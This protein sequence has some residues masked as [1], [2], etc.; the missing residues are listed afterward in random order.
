MRELAV[1]RRE[2]HVLGTA[3]LAC[4]GWCRDRCD[5]CRRRR[6]SCAATGQERDDERSMHHRERLLHRGLVKSLPKPEG[7]LSWYLRCATDAE[8]CRPQQP[9][10]HRTYAALAG[11]PVP[12]IVQIY[13]TDVPTFELHP[14]VDATIVIGR[15]DD[16]DIVIDDRRASRRH[17]QVAFDHDRWTIEDLG[18]HNGTFVDA[19]RI[20]G[21]IHVDGDAVLATG[22]TVFLLV[23]D[24]RALRGGITVRDRVVFGPKLAAVWETVTRVAQQS[25]MLHILGET[26]SGK[27]LVARHYHASRPT[28]GPFVAVNCAAVP[29]LLAERLFFG[30]RKGAYSGADADSDGYLVAAEGGVLFLDEIGELSLDVQA[31]L[32]RAIE[33]H[34]VLSLG[35]S[36]PR[37]VELAICSATHVDLR[38]AVKQRRFR[39]DLYFRVASPMVALPPLRERREEI[40]ALVASA[41]TGTKVRAHASF[42]EAALVRPWPGNARELLSAVANA[43]S[44]VVAP[45]TH[46][47]MAQLGEHAGAW[48]TSTPASIDPSVRDVSDPETAKV[49]D[50]LRAEQGNVT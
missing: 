3:D 24:L 12:G 16:C 22:N 48:L 38:S 2:R 28:P 14:T 44:L 9:A 23:P 18:S 20:E 11:T 35:A 21:S 46:V 25:A 49:C 13:A 27:E 8:L 50:A 40:P 7:V 42:V 30:A 39:E 41:L 33:T 43:A 31:K 36:R 4:G 37:M 45:E 10:A 6:R 29:A 17:A 5:C 19:A 34:E 1:A 32:L 47:K 15:G 26:G